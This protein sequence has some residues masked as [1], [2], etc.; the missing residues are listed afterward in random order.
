MTEWRRKSKRK[1]SGGISRTS[2]RCDK[3]KAWKGGDFL[4]AAVDVGAEASQLFKKRTLGGGTKSKLAVS[5]SANVVDPKTHK[6]SKAK[7]ETVLYNAANPLYVRRN[8]VTK[9]SIIS[10]SLGGAKHSARVT[11]KPGSHGVVNAILLSEAENKAIEDAKNKA[12]KE[13]PHK[14]AKAKKE[15]KEA[16]SEPEKK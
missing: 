2:R 9:G 4:G 14:V 6:V 16:A 5:T 3:K 13:K 12:K 11:S 8:F 15:K 10:V 7:I 1:V